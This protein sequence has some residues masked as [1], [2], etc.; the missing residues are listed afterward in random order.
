MGKR[1]GGSSVFL[2]GCINDVKSAICQHY[3]KNHVVLSFCLQIHLILM[4]RPIK[5][6]GFFPKI[7]FFV[8]VAL[9]NPVLVSPS[10]M[11]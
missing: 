5:I 9:D 1:A 2:I 8:T 4:A 10:D 11:T 6:I 3:K 7:L